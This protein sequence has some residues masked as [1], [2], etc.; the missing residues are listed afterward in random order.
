[1]RKAWLAIIWMTLGA[2]TL[3]VVAKDDDAPIDVLMVMQ[4]GLPG[5][6]PQVKQLLEKRGCRIQTAMSIEPLTMDL[7]RGFHTVVLAGL[8]DYSGGEYYSPGGT[9]LDTVAR[10]IAV[11]HDY[12]AAGGGLVVVP[13]IGGI[14]MATTFNDFLAPWKLRLGCETVRDAASALSSNSVYCW[15]RAI[16]RHPAAAG[17]RALAYPSLLMRWDDQYPIVPLVPD[18]GAWTV[19]ARGEKTSRGMRSLS[20][21]IWADGIGGKAPALAAVREVGKG[22]VA[23]VGLNPYYLL[24]FAFSKATHIGEMSVGALSGIA[25]SVGDG[26]TPSDWGL[27]TANLLRWTG[28][29]G[30]GA[31][32]GGRKTPWTS[33]LTRMPWAPYP[34]LPIPEWLMVDWSHRKPAQTWR[35]HLPVPGSW[36]GQY[37]W[38]SIPDPRLTAPQQMN[39]VLIGARSAYS[40]GSGT[41]AEWAA[42]AK[43]AGYKMLVFTERFESLS[44]TNWTRF[45]ADC[46]ANSSQDFVCLQGFDIADSYGNRFLVMGS[47][48]F[49]APGILTK[50]GK[51]IDESNRFSLSF[52]RHL[53]SFHR[54]GTSALSTELLR[55]FQAISVYTYAENDGKF[56]L[57]DNG[58]PSYHWELQAA[59][60]PV[61]IAVHE[62]TN[63]G[64]VAVNSTLG[65]QLIVPSQDARDAA[66]YFRSGMAHFFE[67]PQRYFIT[68]GPIIDLWTIVNSEIGPPELNR[69]HFRAF[70]G[71]TAGE[72]N[73][74]IATA[75]L[76]DRDGIERRWTPNSASFRETVDGDHGYQ[77]YFMLIVTDS[78]GRR[79]I[80]PALR[81][82]TKGYYQRC[83]DRQN[84]FGTAITY[85]GIWAG[86][87]DFNYYLPQV[88]SPFHNE[89][90]R[91]YG[92]LLPGENLANKFLFPFASGSLTFT[93]ML[94]DER[95]RLDTRYGMDSWKLHN[96]MPTRTYELYAR[97]GIWNDMVTSNRPAGMDSYLSRLCDIDVTM[98][99]REPVQPPSTL[100]PIIHTVP[101][102]A[103]YA[104]RDG[105]RLVASNL[106]G[107]AD[108]LLDLPAG[109][110]LGTF[111]LLSPM[112][113]S[114]RGDLGWRSETY[115]VLP[116][117]TEWRCHYLHLAHQMADWRAALAADGHPPWSLTLTQGT[118]DH[119]PGP[120]RLQAQDNGV[121]GRLKAGGAI[122]V[123]PMTVSGL[124]AN[125]PA[126]LWTP[127]KYMDGH[128]ADAVAVTRRM[129]D[130]PL[131]PGTR[132]TNGETVLNYIGIRDGVGYATLDN[133]ADT[134]FFVGNTLTATHPALKLA[135]RYWTRTGAGLE[136]HNPTDQP[137]QARITSTAA[138][139]D[140]L[141]VDLPVD[142]PPATTLRIDLPR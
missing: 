105:D 28:E 26:Q 1:M 13:S 9:S 21:G 17:V 115:R 78:K 140:R 125:W 29:A 24:A 117:G 113:V 37:F 139:T 82:V 104:Y 132:L 141:R 63:P 2:S 120:V 94:V 48:N 58:L 61:P 30:A 43:A 44:P 50:D 27:L 90:L 74:T 77:R 119:A 18:D 52:A 101:A 60:N 142:V 39:K 136:V 96:T 138:I 66:R 8:D 46:E 86:T 84:F 118:Q 54:P 35:E 102:N 111:L 14:D 71:A 72:T 12:V 3:T 65:F 57:V 129:A 131:F 98:R 89:T 135:F 133:S 41:V 109:A 85:S 38:D 10:N 67:N 31:G 114:G 45:M 47:V 106:N 108:S 64:Q 25:Y 76:F 49:P 112:T 42:A 22:R 137:I 51:A 123:L 11:L 107:H 19:L 128:R 103:A 5:V 93:D 75:V 68:E 32:F 79:A 127:G 16:Q 95:Y 122:T 99:L 124:N 97:V 36:R 134:P 92:R 59:G 34:D 55:H 15:T 56:I 20:G 121:V 87:G 6:D 62:M 110:T 73:A 70:V 40:D 130:V 100:F 33:Q 4:G 88:P 69:D 80:S 7:L 23:V 116:R 81:T 126:A 91:P 53:V 83:S